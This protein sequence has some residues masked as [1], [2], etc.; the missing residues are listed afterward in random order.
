LRTTRSS[1]TAIS[2]ALRTASGGSNR[3]CARGPTAGATAYD[4]GT[5]A[6][7]LRGQRT[8]N[9]GDRMI[10]REPNGLKQRRS[11]VDLRSSAASRRLV[12][13]GGVVRRT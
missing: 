3:T 9:A 6:A 7:S 1:I 2:F 8:G 12:S 5:A 4:A 13:A 11:R 10:A